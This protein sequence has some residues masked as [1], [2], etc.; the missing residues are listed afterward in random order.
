MVAKTF[1]IN[2]NGG[3]D[4]HEKNHEE[5]HHGGEASNKNSSMFKKQLGRM[6]DEEDLKRKINSLL[7]VF[8]DLDVFVAIN[9]KGGNC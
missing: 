9:A 5:K 6:I 1:D 2:V 3:E 8:L 4:Q 7:L